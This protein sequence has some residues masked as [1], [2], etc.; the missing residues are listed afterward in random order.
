MQ[1]NKRTFTQLV[2][3]YIR[4]KRATGYGFEKGTQ[5]LR[6]IVCLQNEIDHDL[7]MLSR[8]LANCWA[9]KTASR[10]IPSIA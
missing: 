6:R 8:E 9:E 7:P 3:E 1:R 2:D 4:E 10:R 5:V